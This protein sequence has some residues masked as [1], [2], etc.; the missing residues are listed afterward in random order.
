MDDFVTKL[1]M[2]AQLCEF[3]LQEDDLIRDRIVCGLKDYSVTERL[4]REL[5]DEL[6]LKR[7]IEIAQAAEASKQQM[8]MLKNESNVDLHVDDV[9]FNRKSKDIRK[10]TCWKCNKRHDFGKCTAFGHSC[11]RCGEKKSFRYKLQQ[12]SSQS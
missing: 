3:G 12:H 5:P 11:Y 4:L 6:T 8:R 2:Q 10:G 1:K 7:A 9:R